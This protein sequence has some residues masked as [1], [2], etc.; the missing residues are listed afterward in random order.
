MKSRL[1]H[2]ITSILGIGLF[3][4]TGAMWYWEQVSVWESI[5]MFLLGI[6]LLLAKDT[7]IM[8]VIFA[9]LKIKDDK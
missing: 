6:L 5:P 3:I 1:K 7:S 9:V 4:F 8:K 2:W